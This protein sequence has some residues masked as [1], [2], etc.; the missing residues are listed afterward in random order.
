MATDGPAANAAE[1]SVGQ[2]LAELT[3]VITEQNKKIDELLTHLKRQP[4][5]FERAALTEGDQPE[6]DRPLLDDDQPAP[7]L[8][9]AETIG[10]FELD[11][12]VL[13]FHANNKLRT[14]Q[15][16]DV[17]ARLFVKLFDDL[18][19]KAR[20]FG[21]SFDD[22]KRKDLR[23]TYDSEVKVIL[24]DPKHGFERRPQW[25]GLFTQLETK[26][27]Q[28]KKGS[29][30]TFNAQKPSHYVTAFTELARGFE[31]LAENLKAGRDLP[32][33][34][35][36]NR[37]QSS[38]A[39]TGYGGGMGGATHSAVRH[40]RIMNRIDYRYDRRAYRIQ[41]ISGR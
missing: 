30:A 20:A 27:E 32:P 37:G 38:A 15:E 10:P 22:A 7:N 29:P 24:D 16:P 35:F 21:E 25:Q 1:P 14:D 13:D 40:A 12:F 36:Q 26:L 39:A 23:Q 6:G 17:T 11:K 33:S 41:R 4:A 3:R 19:A 34:Y 31:K 18:A 2:A 28:A 5:A 9:S 8:G